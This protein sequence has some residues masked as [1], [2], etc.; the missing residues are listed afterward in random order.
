MN[1][2]SKL[3]ADLKVAILPY[4]YCPQPDE[5]MRDVR[6]YAH[7]YRRLPFYL[8]AFPLGCPFYDVWDCIYY[9]LFIENPASFDICAILRRSHIITKDNSTRFIMNATTKKIV[10]IFWALLTVKERVGYLKI[11]ATPND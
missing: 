2:I 4:T 10:R 9:G 8:P 6:H 3:P 11:M 7:T 5:L 1:I